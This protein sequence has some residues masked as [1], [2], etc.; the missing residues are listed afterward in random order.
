MATYRSDNWRE[1]T[2]DEAYVISQDVS[3]LQYT[4]T[5]V[6]TDQAY[7][8]MEDGSLT[9]IPVVDVRQHPADYVTMTG[10]LEA[11]ENQPQSHADRS[12]RPALM[13]VWPVACVFV[14]LILVALGL[15]FNSQT[16]RFVWSLI[17]GEPM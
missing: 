2:L 12:A 16:T 6:D 4:L 15:V 13:P 5:T 7:V 9:T 3:A 11:F 17:T 10:V 1:V 14:G 8:Y